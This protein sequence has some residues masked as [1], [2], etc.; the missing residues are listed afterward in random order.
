[1]KKTVFFIVT[2]FLNSTFTYANRLNDSTLTQ[3]AQT[4][5]ASS[6]MRV[7][8]SKIAGIKVNPLNNMKMINLK[9]GSLALTSDF[10]IYSSD[11]IYKISAKYQ[12]STSI[13]KD[14]SI[15][16]NANK[17]NKQI[18]QKKYQQFTTSN[19]PQPNCTEKNASL[20]LPI[21]KKRAPNSVDDVLKITIGAV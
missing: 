19:S 5:S 18:G 10:C 12:K 20:T 8:V 17:D 15:S 6:S 13:L 14:P 11:E 21:F 7:S 3:R 2:F 1:M 9:D 16:W 4:K